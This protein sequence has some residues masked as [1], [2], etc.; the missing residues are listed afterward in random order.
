MTTCGH[1]GL[2]NLLLTTLAGEFC[3]VQIPVT[4]T[5]IGASMNMAKKQTK[6]NQPAI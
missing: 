6:R 1:S 5:A 3:E 4:N 2:N